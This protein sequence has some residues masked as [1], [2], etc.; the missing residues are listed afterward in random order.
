MPSG[1]IPPI[2][3]QRL[4]L[5]LRALSGLESEGEI[6]SQ[7]LGRRVGISSAQIRKDLSYF[8]GF[9]KQGA[10]YEVGRLREKLRQI[11]KVDRE[12]EVVVVGV[13]ALGH[14][15]A[16]YAGFNNRGFR[17]V[18]AFDKDPR[19]IGERVGEVVV[20]DVAHMVNVI[21]R[22]KAKVAIVAVPTSQAQEV[23]DALVRAGV[24]AILNYAPTNLNVPDG[25]RVRHIDPVAG[26][27]SMTY[28][29]DS[30]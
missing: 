21:K 27:Q 7:E 30:E 3:I 6:T 19:V 15:I 5:Y 14:A 28:Y 2:V 25:V 13:G 22:L 29:L 23:A 20:Q 24:R 11:L 12:W 1:E 17:V 4:P 16:R 26:L 18:A 10:G 8:G 9:G